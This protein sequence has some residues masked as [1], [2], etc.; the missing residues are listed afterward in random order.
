MILQPVATKLIESGHLTCTDAVKWL[1]V[2]T[3][4]LNLF[5]GVT[6]HSTYFA[7]QANTQLTLSVS[8][9]VY[10][11][12]DKETQQIRQIWFCA[13]LQK[14]AFFCQLAS[15][16]IESIVKSQNMSC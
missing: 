6:S 1:I 11:L 7:L 3:C 12:K 2:Q 9:L 4:L 14:G 10:D 5:H 16:F 8:S 15:Q 13:Y